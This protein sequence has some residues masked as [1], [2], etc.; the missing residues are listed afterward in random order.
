MSAVWIVTRMYD[1]EGSEILCVFSDK[2]DL[3]TIKSYVMKTHFTK[4]SPS[5]SDEWAQDNTIDESISQHLDISLVELDDSKV[6]E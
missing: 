6:V 2:I 4:A 3:D 5:A 1:Y